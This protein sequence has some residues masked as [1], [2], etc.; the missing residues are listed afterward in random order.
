MLKTRIK[1]DME[2]PRSRADVHDAEFTNEHKRVFRGR[3]AAART[4]GRIG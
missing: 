4:L 2:N 1:L 3:Q